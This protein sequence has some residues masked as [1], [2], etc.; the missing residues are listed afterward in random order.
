VGHN[1]NPPPFAA[2]ATTR[3]DLNSITD[4]G[5]RDDLNPG[6]GFEGKL[7]PGSEK[8][9]PDNPPGVELPTGDEAPVGGGEGGGKPSAW[10]RKMLRV[11]TRYVNL[12]CRIL[13]SVN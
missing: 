4:A 8:D 10:L 5:D 7:R 11:I 3:A 13:R 1:Q 6:G 2:D 9:V 12:A